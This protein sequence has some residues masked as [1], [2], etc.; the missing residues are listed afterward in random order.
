MATKI[1][2]VELEDGAK[3]TVVSK[4]EDKFA[5]GFRRTGANTVAVA[6]AICVEGDKFKH[7]VARNLL[8]A[9][10][11]NG[12]TMNLRVPK[13]Y[14]DDAVAEYVESGMYYGNFAYYGKD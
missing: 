8:Q 13:G 14:N 11:N 3:I 6:T 1:K 4:K 2:I 12:Q 9:R 10:F 7:S 5:Y